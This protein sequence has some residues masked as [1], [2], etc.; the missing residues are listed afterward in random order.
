MQELLFLSGFW[1]DLVAFDVREP[2]SHLSRVPLRGHMVDLTGLA[3][4]VMQK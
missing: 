4:L 3:G 2:A 1:S